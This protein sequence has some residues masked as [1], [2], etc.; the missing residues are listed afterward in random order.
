[1]SHQAIL[2]DCC[3]HTHILSKLVRSLEK[4]GLTRTSFSNE[5]IAPH[6]S[7]CGVALPFH[8]EKI[9][10]TCSPLVRCGWTGA[11]EQFGIEKFIPNRKSVDRTWKSLRQDLKFLNSHFVAVDFVL[12][13]TEIIIDFVVFAFVFAINL[14]LFTS[15]SPFL[16]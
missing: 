4:Y 8:E 3:C 6:S 15:F 11:N 9:N 1:M 10:G 13:P 5:R 7:V 14:D 12:W 2:H 16:G